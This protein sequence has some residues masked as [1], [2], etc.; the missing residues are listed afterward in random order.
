MT[1]LHQIEHWGDTHHPKWVDIARIGLGLFLS[2]K[3]IDFLRNMNDIQGLAGSKLPFSSF[4]LV[5]VLHYVV[6]AHLMGGILLALGTMTRLACII[7]IPILI[8]AV[9][10][11]NS[12]TGFWRPFSELGVSILVLALLI[13]FLVAG[14][15]PW[16]IDKLMVEEKKK[17][18]L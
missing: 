9:F 7:Q 11:I 8:G 15:G 1:L 14:N 6:F 12:S 13:Y 2:Y 5:L 18:R 4:V 16:S 10:F 3:G 17:T